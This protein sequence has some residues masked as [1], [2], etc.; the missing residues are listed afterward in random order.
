MT[1]EFMR[2]RLCQKYPNDAW[3]KKVAKME[4]D[5]VIA[6]YNRLQKDGVIDRPKRKLLYKPALPSPT[7]YYCPGCCTF[8]TADNPQLEECI[9]CGCVK[10]EKIFPP[11]LEEH[12]DEN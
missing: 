6:I 2:Q 1:V 12:Y 8:F 11:I 3:A 7:V 4:D 10:I 5:Q 9:D